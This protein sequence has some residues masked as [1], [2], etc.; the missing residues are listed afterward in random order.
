MVSFSPSER[1][2]PRIS[3]VSFSVNAFTNALAACVRQASAI[4]AH[5]RAALAVDAEVD[6]GDLTLDFARWIQ[7]LEP[8]GEGNPVPTFAMRGATI[9]DA[10]PLGQDGRHLQLTVRRAGMMRG[11]WWNHGDKVEEIRAGSSDRYDI[12][13]TV[14]VSSYGEPHPEFRVVSMSRTE[15]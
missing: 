14:D 15:D 12:V 1:D 9:A 8:F 13:F 6:C 10:R 4:T 2:F 7:E 3:G 11:V 5:E